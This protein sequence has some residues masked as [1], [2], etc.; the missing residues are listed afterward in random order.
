[1]S[2]TYDVSPKASPSVP[3]NSEGQAQCFPQK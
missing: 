1:M 2:Y 3:C